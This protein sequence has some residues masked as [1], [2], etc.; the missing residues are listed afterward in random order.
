MNWSTAIPIAVVMLFAGY[1]LGRWMEPRPSVPSDPGK[2]QRDA[3]QQVANADSAAAAFWQDSVTY[4]RN[5]WKEAASIPP[6]IIIND[7][8]TAMHTAPVDSV[9]RVL[10]SEPR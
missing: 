4:Y 3:K 9:Q 5:L 10:L 6:T 1:V 8:V 7:A 2:E